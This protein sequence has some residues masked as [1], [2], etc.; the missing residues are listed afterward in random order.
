[1]TQPLPQHPAH[2]SLRKI[3]SQGPPLVGGKQQPRTAGR[4][5]GQVQIGGAGSGARALVEFTGRAQ[6]LQVLGRLEEIFCGPA[7]VWQGNGDISKTRQ[8]YLDLM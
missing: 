8:Q 5:R 6:S 3:L 4:N 2:P 7:Q 1:M